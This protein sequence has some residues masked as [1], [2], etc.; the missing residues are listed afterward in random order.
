M[1]IKATENCSRLNLRLLFLHDIARI[2]YSRNRYA[3][4]CEIW[5]S[6][7]HQYIDQ[8]WK[9][10]SIFILENLAVCQKGLG[11]ITA[12]I[13]T[14]FYLVRNPKLIH[15]RKVGDYFR[16]ILHHTPKMEDDA[17]IEAPDFLKLQIISVQ[18][19]FADEDVMTLKVSVTNLLEMVLIQNN[20]IG[21]ANYRGLFDFKERRYAPNRLQSM[22]YNT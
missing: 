13:R 9:R 20:Y 21:C 16:D 18:N 14:C 19:K 6:I 3:E 1:T 15:F 5:E 2:Y 8:D 11:K 12:F 10:I 22:R 4:A 7:S 17:T